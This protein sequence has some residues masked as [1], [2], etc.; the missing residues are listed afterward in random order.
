MQIIQRTLPISIVLTD[1]QRKFVDGALYN[2]KRIY[3]L[4]V[5]QLYCI[6]NAN[7][8]RR[9]ALQFLY[10]ACPSLAYK[11]QKLG[12][13]KSWQNDYLNI[14][15]PGWAAEFVRA[16]EKQAACV[17]PKQL[18]EV[19][20][21]GGKNKGQ[22]KLEPVVR[23]KDGKKQTERGASG[24]PGQSLGLICSTF[25]ANIKSFYTHIKNGNRDA[26][27]PKRFKRH[28]PLMFSNQL[29]KALGNGFYLFGA[30][31][32]TIKLHLPALNRFTSI[33]D[34]KLSKSR[35]GKYSLN[36][37]G[38]ISVETNPDLVNVA[39]ADFGQIR[40]IVLATEVEGKTETASISG[41]NILA[42]KRER[43]Y[44]YRELNRLRSR[45]LKGQFRLYLN[46]EE[47]LTYRQLQKRDNRRQSA[48]KTRKGDDIKYAYKI[49]NQ[50]R[51]GQCL[52]KHSRQDLRLKRK[53]ANVQEYYRTR[54]DYANHC[55]SRAAVDWA[56]SH[57]V[58]QI[59]VGKLDSL[60]KGRKKG[61]RRVRQVSR[62]NRWEMPTQRKYIEEKLEL[63]GSPFENKVPEESEAYTS[64]VCPSC[65]RKHK[66]RG[67]V[68]HCKV[69]KGGCGWI[70]DRDGVGAA[71]FLSLVSTGS[72]GRLM[73][74][75]LIH[76]PI[77]PAIKN[78]GENVHLYPER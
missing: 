8:R 70:G 73:P 74:E 35:S 50:R 68:F 60:P 1:A 36:V 41:K 63:A 39:A 62:N 61:N 53:I 30:E 37:S 31:P 27:L 14:R 20:I 10:F 45:I 18:E 2:S 57:N 54:L 3:N 5:E 12:Y 48:G 51:R 58:G 33:S 47:K 11:F 46:D 32:F 22:I 4:L 15:R 7:K 19:K 69:S 71:N 34:A 9:S 67:R 24:I 23:S 64:Q 25:E 26:E 13:A 52:K 40:A 38:K 42:L 55:V 78:R 76:L 16:V 59:Y 49:I 66:P 72:C 56:L 21:K 6:R 65:G 29:I 43:D 75:P 77:S 28:F 44:R 17:W